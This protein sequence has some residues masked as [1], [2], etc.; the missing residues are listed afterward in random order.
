MWAVFVN[1]AGIIV[2]GL[3]GTFA[4][5]LIPEK[6]EQALMT[7]VGLCII[8]IGIKGALGGSND[9]VM[10][11]SLVIGGI[12]GTLLDIDAAVNRLGQAVEKRISPGKEG[13]LSRGFVS[14]SLLFCVG[15]MAVI[16]SIQAG[17]SKEYSTLYTKALLDM[18]ISVTMASSLGIGVCF[19]S[20]SVFLYQ[21]AICLL[22][23]FVEPYLGDYPRGELIAA[24]S[25]LIMAI[26][27]NMIGVTKI[28]IANFLP[29]V[30][31]APLL[32][33]II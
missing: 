17:L 7:G 26:G 10:I 14:G 18:I 24:G 3:A 16:G 25:L 23:S 21:G 5:K 22:A 1:A 29:A 8:C 32:C 31:V 11:L 33:L 15:A 27:T 28:K 20:V 19:S 30:F 12:I 6:L 9:L 2:G 4:K 13:S